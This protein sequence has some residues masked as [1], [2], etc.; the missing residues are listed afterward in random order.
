MRL[1]AW[2]LREFP[3]N[4]RA[5]GASPHC[6]P[7]PG[8][9]A[10][11]RGRPRLHSAKLASQTLH[12]S[13]SEI[14]QELIEESIRIR[15]CPGHLFRVGAGRPNSQDRPHPSPCGNSSATSFMTTTPSGYG[16]LF[17]G[18]PAQLTAAVTYY[19]RSRKRSARGRGERGA[20]E[21]GARA[22]VVRSE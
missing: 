14:A 15:E 9:S 22:S 21:R 6:R 13:V 19:A 2:T 3:G 12:R 11:P 4:L 16:R 17:R 7:A 5:M 1:G 10:N 18:C 8:V 20:D